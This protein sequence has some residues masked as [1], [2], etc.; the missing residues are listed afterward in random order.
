MALLRGRDSS[1]V[2]TSSRSDERRLVSGGTSS[3]RWLTVVAVRLPPSLDA[4]IDS[5]FL[6][7]FLLI[8]CGKKE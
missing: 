8:D 3:A 1:T 7:Y 4:S 2:T 6:R 5:G